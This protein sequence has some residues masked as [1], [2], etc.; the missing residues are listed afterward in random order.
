MTLRQTDNYIRVCM[1]AWLLCEACIHTE[2]EQLFPNEK[3][4]QACHDCADSCLSIVCLFINNRVTDQKNIFDCFLYCR[5]CYNECMLHKEEDIEY[6]G[7]VCDKCAESMKE[8]MLF[9]LN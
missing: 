2:N 6:C 7:A 3:L 9:H 1:N 5:E 8:L 4:V